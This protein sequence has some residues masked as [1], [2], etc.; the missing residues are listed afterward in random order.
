MAHREF[1]DSSRI[2]W[3]VWDVYPA[4]GDRRGPLGD[5]RHFMRESADRRAVLGVAGVRVSPEYERGWLAFQSGLERRRLAPV[6]SGWEGLD[7][8]DLERLCQAARPVGRARRL[9]E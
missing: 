5:R 1:M 3:E 4:L 7:P 8:P 6:P 9:V 2:T